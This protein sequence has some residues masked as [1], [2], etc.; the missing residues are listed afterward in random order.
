MFR[1][2]AR[3]CAALV[4]AVLVAGCASTSIRSAWFDPGYK[5]GPFRKILVAGVHGN[6][7]D[8]R[9][10]EDIFT[11]KLG[12]AGIEGVPGYRFLHSDAAPDEA[13]WTAAV[14][15]SGADGLLTVRLLRVDTKTRVTTTMMSGPMTLSCLKRCSLP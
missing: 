10:F 7:A 8:S 5:G 1:H 9:V 14:T 13:A 4:A 3:G 15:R 11:Q 6:L 12:A 2:L